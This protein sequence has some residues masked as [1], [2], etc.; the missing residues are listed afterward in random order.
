N[1]VCYSHSARKYR[2]DRARAKALLA[3]LGLADRNGDGMLEDGAGQAVRFS[4]L[5]QTQHIRG[6][7]A[8]FV[9]GQLRKAG[10]VLDVVELDPQ[11]LFGR[12]AA[13]DWESICYAFQMSA[14]HAAMNLD[15]WLRSCDL[16]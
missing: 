2:Y 3:A 12:Y 5:T 8:A 13:G 7:T 14:F 6:R 4:T 16:H 10:I 1:R 9:Q 15:L 11:S